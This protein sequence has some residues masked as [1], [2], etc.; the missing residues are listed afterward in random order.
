MSNKKVKLSKIEIC[1]KWL[2]N[3]NINPET[4]R[5]IKEIGAIYKKLAK[6]CLDNKKQENYNLVERIN[7]YLIIKKII[8]SIKE[9]NNLI[10]VYTNDKKTKENRYI[11]ANQIIL[12]KK[13]DDSKLDIR[14]FSHLKTDIKYNNKFIVKINNQNILNNNDLTI[15]NILTNKVIKSKCP[16]F[17]IC[18]GSLES[19]NIDDFSIINDK[20]LLLK[21]IELNNG[22]LDDY[23]ETE[24]N[25]DIF[26]TISQLLLSIMFFHYYTKS[27]HL[28]CFSS[29]FQYH[30]IKPGGYFH[31]NI[32]GIDYYL[33]NKGYLWVISDYTYARKYNNGNIRVDYDFITL[34]SNYKEYLRNV[35][36][37]IIST[38]DD[39]LT[40]EY[41]NITKYKYLYNVNIEILK[42]LITNV[43]SFTKIKPSNIINEKPFI[44]L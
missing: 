29:N 43:K 22:D 16:H 7:Y 44:I 32:Y 25:I 30:K 19:N 38:L 21:I 31:Y 28:Q 5:K 39:N 8:M 10:S 33:K 18:Y 41:Y 1:D 37:K 20:H 2:S 14:Y 36:L 26:N 42:F 15:S 3:K 17:P 12:D 6:K 4:L 35:D 9:K 23:F 24:K 27:S 13:V 11:I 40:F 34:L